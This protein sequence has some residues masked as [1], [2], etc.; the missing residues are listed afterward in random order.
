MSFIDPNLWQD[1]SPIDRLEVILLAIPQS[2]IDE[3]GLD[4]PGALTLS[5][6]AAPRNWPRRRG[7]PGGWIRAP[8]WREQGD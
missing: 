4:E 8:Q 7:S 2:L 3:V 1:L 6:K 5:A